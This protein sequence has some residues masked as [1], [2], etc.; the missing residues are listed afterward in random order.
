LQAEPFPQA[1]SATVVG[2]AMRAGFAMKDS[3]EATIEATPDMFAEG[4]GK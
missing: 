3:A 4:A 2:V 1:G